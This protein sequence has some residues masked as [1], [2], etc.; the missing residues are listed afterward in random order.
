[1]M[2]GIN[3]PDTVREWQKTSEHEPKMEDFA[4][5]LEIAYNSTMDHVHGLSTYV[6]I[7]YIETPDGLFHDAE[8]YIPFNGKIKWYMEGPI[9]KGK[10]EVGAPKYWREKE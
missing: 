8:V 2:T 3:R 9:G 7:S 4:D 1:M 6:E 10:K 5:P